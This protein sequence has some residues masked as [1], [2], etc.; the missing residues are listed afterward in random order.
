MERNVLH[1]DVSKGNV[2][3]T[4]PDE[5]ARRN[6]SDGI[7]TTQTT[8]FRSVQYLLNHRHVQLQGHW[9]PVITDAL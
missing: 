5:G 8:E 2:L 9:L 7:G 1:R 3:F 6:S 4:K